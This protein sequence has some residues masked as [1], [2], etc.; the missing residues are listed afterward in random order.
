[1]CRAEVSVLDWP[2]KLRDVRR[3]SC[4]F[5]DVTGGDDSIAWFSRT[6]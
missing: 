1:M 2:R 3:A 6:E 4:E 5:R